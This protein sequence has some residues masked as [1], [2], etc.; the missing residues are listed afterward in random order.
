MVRERVLNYC[1]NVGCS[2]RPYVFT[3]VYTFFRP[4]CDR[5]SICAIVVTSSRL[6]NIDVTRRFWSI[7]YSHLLQPLKDIA[8]VSGKTARFE[9]IVQGEPVS[10]V[11][12]SCNG[13]VLENS[14]CYQT[15][16]RNG[17][18]RLTIP[19]AYQCEYGYNIK[20]NQYGHCWE[21]TQAANDNDKVSGH[22]VRG[23]NRYNHLYMKYI[24]WF[25]I[26]NLVY[27]D[28]QA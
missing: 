15:Q 26:Y 6:E 10:D 11:I 25:F 4:N 20:Q 13:Q 7:D 1:H 21:I 23:R 24:S 27:I 8:V 2:H 16:Y 18:C 17:V 3:G 19:R 14:D 12:W 9:C 22:F 5:F 28:F